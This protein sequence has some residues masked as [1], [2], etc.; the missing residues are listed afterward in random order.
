MGF[1]DWSGIILVS[2]D[3]VGLC[4]GFGSGGGYRGGFCEN[5]PEASPVSDRAGASQLQDRPISNGGSDCGQQIKKEVT[6]EEQLQLE[7]GVRI[8]EVNS[9]V[10]VK[11]S[12]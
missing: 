6:A 9:L 11:V 4:P 7:R 12:E 10:Y 5:L 2:E 3:V 8:R 1:G